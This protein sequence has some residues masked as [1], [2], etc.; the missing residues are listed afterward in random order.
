MTD[1]AKWGKAYYEAH[2]TEIL[3]AEKEK[4]RWL[5]YYQKNKD[6]IAE[7]NRKRYYEKRGLAV[8]EKVPKVKKTKPPAP[9]PAIVER[10]EKLVEELRVLAPQVVKPKRT[11]KIKAPASAGTIEHVPESPA[12]QN[13]VEWSAEIVDPGATDATAPGC[14]A[15]Q[16]GEPAMAGQN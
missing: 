13:I 10:F 2:K 6:L 5:D 8:P 4:K 3:N 7:R 15:T 12:P 1:Y 9:D 11:R 16:G 14:E